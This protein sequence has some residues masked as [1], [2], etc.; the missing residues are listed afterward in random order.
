MKCSQHSCEF[1]DIL[2]CVKYFSRAIFKTHKSIMQCI[3]N[4]F[5]FLVLSTDTQSRCELLLFSVD[6][7]IYIK[8]KG[9]CTM[10]I[11]IKFCTSKISYL[12]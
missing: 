6:I 7:Y 8:N 10:V 9:I 2:Q 12:T 11:N 3:T 1:T 5:H 4:D